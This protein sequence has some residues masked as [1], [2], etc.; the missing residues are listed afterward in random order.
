MAHRPGIAPSNSS[1]EF[2]HSVPLDGRSEADAEREARA[3]FAEALGWEGP[4]RSRVVLDWWGNLAW[5]F[6]AD[7]DARENAK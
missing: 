3:R 7:V 5:E 2:V 1:I 4:L 6:R